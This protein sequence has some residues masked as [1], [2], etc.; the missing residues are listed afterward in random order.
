ADGAHSESLQAFDEIGV[1]TFDLPRRSRLCWLRFNTSRVEQNRLPVA[2]TVAPPHL[3]AN[4][5][6]LLGVQRTPSAD[7]VQRSREHT[8]DDKLMNTLSAQTTGACLA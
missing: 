4:L 1:T 7:V 5:L 3:Q 2:A 6:H 8:R